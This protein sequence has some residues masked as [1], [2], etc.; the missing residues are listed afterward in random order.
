MLMF[1]KHKKEL[2]SDMKK[3][4]VI[5]NQVLMIY[6]QCQKNSKILW[7][8][9]ISVLIRRGVE[10]LVKS[11]MGNTPSSVLNAKNIF[12]IWIVSRRV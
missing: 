3:L 5:N 4:H 8:R 10:Y 6:I 12:G 1:N 9:L 11:S 7:E 2:Y